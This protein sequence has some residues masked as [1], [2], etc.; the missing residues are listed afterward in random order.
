MRASVGDRLVIKG[1]HVG[2]PDRDAEILEP[3]G[4]AGEPPWLVRWSDDGHVGL[5]VPGP[6]AVLEQFRHDASASR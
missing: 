3:Q 6:D 2:Q 5:F 1:H 4:L